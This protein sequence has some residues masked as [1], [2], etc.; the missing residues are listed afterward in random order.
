MCTLRSTSSITTPADSFIRAA[1]KLIHQ[2]DSDSNKR[3]KPNRNNSFW[4]KEYIIKV[5]RTSKLNCKIPICKS[6]AISGKLHQSKYQHDGWKFSNLEFTNAMASFE[7]FLWCLK[8]FII[9]TLSL[10]I[11]SEWQVIV[12]L[13][14]QF[15]YAGLHGN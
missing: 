7:T 1:S 13:L 9:S 4:W 8:S 15:F 5:T 12:Q 2:K 14:S 3:A 6:L 10:L 11:I